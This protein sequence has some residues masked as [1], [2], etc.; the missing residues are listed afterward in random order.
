MNVSNAQ[1]LHRASAVLSEV[2]A[3]HPHLA[4][5]LGPMSVLLN[6]VAADVLGHTA[7]QLERMKSIQA[8]LKQANECLPAPGWPHLE[9]L[10]RL[11]PTTPAD[12]H[13]D[14]L[15]R[16]LDRLN[17]ALIEVQAW[18]ETAA[19]VPARARLLHD[20]WAHLDHEAAHASRLVP[21]M[22]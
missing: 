20:I 3:Q 10:I 12:Y 11:A 13:V 5:R 1:V 19:N 21:Q 16:L 7:A 9:A 6:A 18:C 15:D 14:A 8:L 22:W 17:E 4:P 2:I